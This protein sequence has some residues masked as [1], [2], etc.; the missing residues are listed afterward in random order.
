MKIYKKKGKKKRE[1][2]FN[3]YWP[4][5]EKK[6]WKVWNL[7]K[8][9]FSVIGIIYFLIH[10]NC[11][12][13]KRKIYYYFRL[14]AFVF[15]IAFYCYFFYC[16]LSKEKKRKRKKRKWMKNGS[17]NLLFNINFCYYK[18][19]LLSFISFL[20][21]LISV[22]ISWKKRKK[23]NCCRSM[24][25]ADLRR[26]QRNLGRLLKLQNTEKG[27]RFLGL[28]WDIKAKGKW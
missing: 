22:L 13:K 19:L 12:S 26:L 16:Y 24:K 27:Q 21:L 28:N 10:F 25:A 14:Q 3:A 5:F 1:K 8:K 23:E 2:W 9:V 20:L 17:C 7:K 4:I 15:L 6:K 18:F 11:F